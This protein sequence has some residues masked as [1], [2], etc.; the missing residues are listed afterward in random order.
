MCLG[1][2]GGG[3][4]EV[5]AMLKQGESRKRFN[6]V[7]TREF[8]VLVILKGGKKFPSLKEKKEG[9]GERAPHRVL[10]CLEVGG[11]GGGRTQFHTCDFPIL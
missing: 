10:P 5:F 6:V 3:G 1:G 9:G 7:F 11:G 2:G 4:G 8:E